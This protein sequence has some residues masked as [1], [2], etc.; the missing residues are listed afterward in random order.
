MRVS[1]APQK[2]P[3]FVPAMLRTISRRTEGSRE[4][5]GKRAS[6]R[7]P[8][9]RVSLWKKGVSQRVASW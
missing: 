3:V 7:A 2:S 4:A 1:L 9:S 6:L 5:S 8:D